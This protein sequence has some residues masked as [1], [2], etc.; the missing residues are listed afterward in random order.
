[1]KCRTR[2]ERFLQARERLYQIIHD[3]VCVNRISLGL[4]M[5][6][7]PFLEGSP[8]FFD[9]SMSY[10]QEHFAIAISCST[11]IGVDLEDSFPQE[12]VPSFTAI[13]SPRE[14]FLLNKYKKQDLL[15]I[16]VRKEAFLKMNGVGLMVDPREVEVDQQQRALYIG[17]QSLS[18]N[19][20]RLE[21]N[22]T[23]QLFTVAM[24]FPSTADSGMTVEFITDSSPN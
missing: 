11:D 4:G 12:P 14:F 23:E 17:N 18:Y 10:G 6:G 2:Q 8:H 16:W 13:C 19:E 7:K 24:A 3:E 5:F 9:F 20:A 22:R 1:M 21:V 15:N